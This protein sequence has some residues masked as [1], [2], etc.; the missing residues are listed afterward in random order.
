[1]LDMRLAIQNLVAYAMLWQP[2]YSGVR[3]EIR[4][5]Y[6]RLEFLNGHWPTLRRRRQLEEIWS[7]FD[8]LGP[9]VLVMVLREQFVRFHPDIAFVIRSFL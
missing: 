6:L 5:P 7:L 1:M 8:T 4:E 9:C 2:R 3:V